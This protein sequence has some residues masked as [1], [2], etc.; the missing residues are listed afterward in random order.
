MK[1]E[2]SG[3]SVTCLKSLLVLNLL[4]AIFTYIW[5]SLGLAEEANPLMDFV[6]SLSPTGFILYK[7]FI[8]NLCVLLLWRMREQRLCKVLCVPL[9]CVYAYVFLIHILFLADIT[10]EYLQSGI[11]I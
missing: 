11:A 1:K 8:V 10:Y 2:N 6:I 3:W 9:V 7:V 5:V 4:D